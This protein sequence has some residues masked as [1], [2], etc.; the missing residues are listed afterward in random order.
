MKKIERMS[1]VMI[2]KRANIFY[3]EHAKVLQKDGRVVY[4]T[5]KDTTL[6]HFFNIPDKNTS[7]L[8][9]GKGTS[10]T[11]AA[12]RLLAESN[13]IVGFCGSGGSPLFSANDFV[14]LD[15]KDEYGPTNYAQEWVRRWFDEPLRLEMGKGF[16]KFRKEW[17]VEY[18]DKKSVDIGNSNILIF[19]REIA[20]AAT[21]QDL[22]LAEAKWVKNLYKQAASRYKVENFVRNQ[23]VQTWAE[24]RDVVNA[25]LNHGN[26]L[27]Y[28]M[29]SV[30][31]HGLAIPYCFPVLHGKTR[32][33]ALVFDVADLFKDGPVLLTCFKA[34]A[35]KKSEQENRI[36]LIRAL[37]DEGVLDRCMTFIAGELKISL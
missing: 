37:Q 29:A 11:D 1:P 7:L 23:E 2:S 13:V 21:T 17:A 32:R 15:P 19:E 35:E 10:I 5:E 33:G 30:V 25:F 9:L 24:R 36:E 28:G 18:W 14:L 27:A 34:M 6:D 12:A 3:L 16:L 4:L 22:L 8:L 31:L 26:Y 20:A